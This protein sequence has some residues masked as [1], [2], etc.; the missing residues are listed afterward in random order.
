SATSTA[1]GAGMMV[2]AASPALG[3][4]VDY[5]VFESAYYRERIVGFRTA[6]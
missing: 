2:H 3:V 6:R 1:M 4:R 5:G